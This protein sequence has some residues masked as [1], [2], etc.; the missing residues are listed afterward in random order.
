M[1]WSPWQYSTQFSQQHSPEV[2]QSTPLCMVPSANKVLEAY[3]RSMARPFE[4]T[5][6]V[7]SCPRMQLDK[8]ASDREGNFTTCS[9]QKGGFNNSN[10]H[11]EEKPS[12]ARPLAGHRSALPDKDGG[13]AFQS[14]I[15]RTR[16][17]VDDILRIPISASRPDNSS[18][19]AVSLEP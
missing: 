11:F 13:C 15:R 10:N 18:C 6:V 17:P 3:A 19:Q 14:P 2:L 9:G 7:P 12:R 4:F 5:Y 1:K 8:H 16:E